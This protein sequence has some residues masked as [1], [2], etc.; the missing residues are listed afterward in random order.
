[1]TGHDL[2]AVRERLCMTQEG[3]GMAIGVHANTIARGERGVIPVSTR[4]AREVSALE[5][6]VTESIARFRGMVADLDPEELKSVSLVL[7]CGAKE[8]ARIPI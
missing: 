2:R 7:Y 5:A 4:T 6:R 3:L 8:L 1:M